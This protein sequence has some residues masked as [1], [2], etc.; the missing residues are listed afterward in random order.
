[1]KKESKGIKDKHT[2]SMIS[3]IL[4]FVLALSNINAVAQGLNDD[5]TSTIGGLCLI[6]GAIAY[7]MAKKRIL[8]V[9]NSSIFR[10]VIEITCIVLSMAVVLMQNN[11][12]Y[13]VQMN[14]VMIGIIPLS[15][16]IA[17]VYLL[18]QK[19]SIQ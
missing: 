10:L 1:M 9:N 14:P 5:I 18:L 13:N 15:V 3:I 2:G 4:G 6:F 12:S 7:R 16:L 19:K 8:G 17:Y 11:L